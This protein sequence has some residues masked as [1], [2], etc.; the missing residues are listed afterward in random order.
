MYPCTSHSAL[1]WGL[2]GLLLRSV[3]HNLAAIS[4]QE[5]PTSCKLFSASLFQ[6]PDHTL[7][8]SPHSPNRGDKFWFCVCLFVCG[9]RITSMLGV[10]EFNYNRLSEFRNRKGKSLSCVHVLHWHETAWNV[11]VSRWRRAPT[12]RKCTK[13]AIHEQNCRF[14]NFN[15]LSFCPSRARCRPESWPTDGLDRHNGL[16]GWTDRQTGRTKG[17]TDE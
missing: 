13:S 3:L 2:Q 14:A 10:L 16:S 1:T 17:R 7:V 15:V 9:V 8:S 5:D 4:L 6:W 11:E 12:A